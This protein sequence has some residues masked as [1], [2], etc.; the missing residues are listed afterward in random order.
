MKRRKRKKVSKPRNLRFRNKDDIMTD[1]KGLRLQGQLPDKVWAYYDKQL[2]QLFCPL[3]NQQ[4]QPFT[5]HMYR[6]AIGEVEQVLEQAGLARGVK[7]L[8]MPDH[9]AVCFRTKEL[10]EKFRE[11]T[12]IDTRWATAKCDTE[13]LM[14]DVAGNVPFLAYV[15][16]YASEATTEAGF[17]WTTCHCVPLQAPEKSQVPEHSQGHSKPCHTAAELNRLFSPDESHF[18]KG[19]RKECVTARILGKVHVQSDL[20]HTP[21]LA[22]LIA[23]VLEYPRQYDAD[24]NGTHACSATVDGVPLVGFWVIEDGEERIFIGTESWF[25]QLDE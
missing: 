25:T 12:G 9:F 7:T 18:G 24:G 2:G 20:P 17:Q 3:G 11:F 4:S 22:N 16:E 13:T 8:A 10:A 21:E 23:A 19:S 5:T 15:N 14:N 1:T 6:E